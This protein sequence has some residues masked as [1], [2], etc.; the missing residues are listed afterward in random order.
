MQVD[1]QVPSRY[2]AIPDPSHQ[3]NTLFNWLEIC[4][5]SGKGKR[6]FL[7]QFVSPQPNR[8]FNYLIEFQQNGLAIS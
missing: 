5:G 3:K 1:L 6:K 2:V 7:M 4:L 8:L